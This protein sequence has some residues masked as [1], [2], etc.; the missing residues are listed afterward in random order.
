MEVAKQLVGWVLVALAACVAV[1]FVATPILSDDLARGMWSVVTW[2]MAIGIAAAVVLSYRRWRSSI[3]GGGKEQAISTVLIIA[4]ILLGLGF[5]ENWF[6]SSLFFGVGAPL[7][8]F[9]GGMWFLINP[10]FVVIIGVVG[11]HLV[12]DSARNSAEG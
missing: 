9:W 5:Y 12:R 6:E 8:E 7:D 10:A 4:S 11:L 2:L 3:H 1:L